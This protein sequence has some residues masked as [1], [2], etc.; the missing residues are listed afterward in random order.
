MEATVPHTSR[1]GHRAF[2]ERQTSAPSIGGSQGTN[3]WKSDNGFRGGYANKIEDWMRDEFP[4]TD[5]RA[6]PHIQSKIS[7]WKKNYYS[8]TN[9]LDRSGAG[10]N[11]HNDFKI[12]CSDDQWDQI[13]KQDTNA[14]TMRGKS[15]PFW[16]DWKIIFG[17]DRATGG[18]A[19]GVGEAVT[20][21]DVDEPIASIGESGDYYPSFEDFLGSEHVQPSFTNDVEDDTSA[22][23][24][25][26]AA[27]AVPVPKKTKCKRTGSDDDSRLISLIDK[28]HAETNARLD[29]LSA[30]IGYEMDLGKF[31]QAIFPHLENIPELTESQRY[32]LCDIIGKE[33]SRL[34]IFTGLPDAKKP[35]YVMRIL[36]KEALY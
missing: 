29:T 31:R 13:V 5:I 11:L 9:I 2:P 34:E 24:G 23:S 20:S 25:Q 18:L 15:W 35:G 22:Q 30:R 21:N 36:E 33:N 27:A 19:E 32:D 4:T 26:N 16:E 8:L 17:K 10:F 28:L 12:D 6:N 7:T 3:G 14:R 1:P